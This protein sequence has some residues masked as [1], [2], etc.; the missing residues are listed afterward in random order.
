MVRHESAR[1]AMQR[2]GLGQVR[3]DTSLKGWVREVLAENPG[4]VSQFHGGRTQVVGFLIGQ[5]MQRSAGRAKPDR[6]RD[7]LLAA[8]AVERA[9]ADAKE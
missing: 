7:L 9:R 6:V 8:L 5:V 3:D 1:S 4:P 2:L